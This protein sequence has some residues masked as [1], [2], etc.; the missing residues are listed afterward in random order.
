MYINVNLLK[1]KYWTEVVNEL[2]QKTDHL[3]QPEF[4]TWIEQFFIG[5]YLTKIKFTDS[6]D[7]WV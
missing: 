2:N 1:P 7:S 3:G 6:I 4:N 5:F